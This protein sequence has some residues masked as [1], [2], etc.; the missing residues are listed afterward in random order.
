M[1]SSINIVLSSSLYRFSSNCKVCFTS[2]KKT[3]SLFGVGSIGIGG[4]SGVSRVGGG[5]GLL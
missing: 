4:G 1:K 3:A 5:A 2:A